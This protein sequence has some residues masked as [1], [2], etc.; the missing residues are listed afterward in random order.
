ME[1]TV[2]SRI[3]SAFHVLRL[4]TRNFC[5]P[6]HAL[7]LYYRYV[8][9]PAYAFNL[10]YRYV[11]RLVHSLSLCYWY[12]YRLVGIRLQMWSISPRQLLFS[13]VP[14]PGTHFRLIQPRVDSIL[15][16]WQFPWSR[17]HLVDRRHCYP[18]CCGGT[19]FLTGVCKQGIGRGGWVVM[20]LYYFPS[21]GPWQLL[22]YASELEQRQ[23]CQ[24]MIS[25]IIDSASPCMCCWVSARRIR[26]GCVGGGGG[27][28]QVM[29]YDMWC[30]PC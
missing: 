7:S 1:A 4:W 20:V 30:H 26:V 6:A 18:L 16:F 12:V 2:K 8:Y 11:C 27:G 17:C 10:C 19:L 25:H 28:S 23:A 24:K 9:R 3:I 29:L 22:K 13:N 21:S 5:R 15:R 14:F